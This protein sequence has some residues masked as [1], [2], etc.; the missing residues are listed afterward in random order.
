V[1][2]IRGPFRVGPPWEGVGYTWPP[3]PQAESIIIVSMAPPWAL[4]QVIC[5]FPGNE[6]GKEN[7]EI[8]CKL[9]N[10]IDKLGESWEEQR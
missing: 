9:L 10:L 4:G 3:E 5:A 6:E 7:A 1:K 2:R 8:V